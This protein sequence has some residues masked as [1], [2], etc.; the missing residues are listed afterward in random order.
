MSIPGIVGRMMSR[1]EQDPIKPVCVK[2]A[3]LI[4]DMINEAVKQ[5]GKKK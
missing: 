3:Q 1:S 4:K 5:I 2:N